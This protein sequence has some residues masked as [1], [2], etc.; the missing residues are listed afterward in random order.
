MLLVEKV[1]LL[2]S[3][4][5]FQNTPEQELIDIAYIMQ[6]IEVEPGSSLFSKGDE[7]NSMYL[8]YKGAVSIHDEA[9][10]FA[11]LEPNEIF[12]ELSLLD[13]QPRSASATAITECVLLKLNQEPFYEV[14]MQNSKVLKGIMRTLCKRLRNENRKSAAISRQLVTNHA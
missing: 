6:E 10:Q 8:V 5:I 4:E 2:K 7:G 1:I 11:V 12:G 14:L 3:T 13:T 9:H